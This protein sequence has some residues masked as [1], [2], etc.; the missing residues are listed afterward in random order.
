M[1]RKISP[2]F[3]VD[4]MI[5][6]LL[7]IT[8]SALVSVFMRLSTGRVKGR[9]SLLAVNYLVCS[10]LGAIYA[11]GN[12][13]CVGATGY[14]SMLLLGLI[15]GGL[16]LLGFVL[17]QRNIRKNGIVLSSL[18]MKLGLL[19]PIVM[20]LIFFRELPSVLQCIGFLIAVA[21]IVL[22]NLEKDT[23]GFTAGLLILLLAGGGCDA[24]SKVYEQ[25]GAP[26]LS[27]Q[28]LFFTFFFAFL[29]C[30][31]LVL[32]KSETPG[33]QELIFGLLIGLPNFFS[34]KFLLAALTQLPAVVVY[35]TFSAATL[36]AVTLAG[37]FLFKEK[38]KNRQWIALGMILLAL[39]AL[40][41]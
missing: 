22:V 24:M 32:R 13:F 17:L 37:V 18:F 20:S 7:A 33:K 25:L 9:F 11:K 40:N 31:I 41:I 21:A 14:G 30:S 10:L 29:L 6:L 23:R 16:Y 15:A 19:V 2:Y 38:L 5:Y 12:I 8:S 4:S 34:A 39:I 1:I 35:P 28:F 36:L 26:A 27:N 3:E